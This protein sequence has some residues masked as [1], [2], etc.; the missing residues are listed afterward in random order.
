MPYGHGASVTLGVLTTELQSMEAPMAR[1]RRQRPYQRR[2]ACRQRRTQ[3][4]YRHGLK[5]ALGN[6]LTG[7]FGVIVENVQNPALRIIE[8]ALR[9]TLTCADKMRR[10]GSP[11]L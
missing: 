10:G 11:M 4:S 3:A 1:S 7:Q 8:L 6:L 2:K 5:D 9:L